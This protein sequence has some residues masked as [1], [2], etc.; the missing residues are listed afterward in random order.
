LKLKATCAVL[1]AAVV[2]SLTSCNTMRRLGK[3]LYV[4]GPGLVTVVPMA[5]CA[6]SY[7]D[8]TATQKGYETGGVTQVLSFPL[9]LIWNT[10]KHLGYWGVHVIDIPLNV[11]YGISEASSF[12][13]EIEPLD[14]YQSTWFD[15]GDSAKSTDAES[16]ETGR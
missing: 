16:G 9:F 4:A 6:D 14:Y 8:A 11:F 7:R 3:D 15:K 10:V 2:L 5:A 13:P 1:L 12:G